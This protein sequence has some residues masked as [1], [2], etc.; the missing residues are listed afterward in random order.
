MTT[1]NARVQLAQRDAESLAVS[2]LKLREIRWAGDTKRIVGKLQDGTVAYEGGR[3]TRY[4]ERFTS[5]SAAITAIGSTSTELVCSAASL[6][7]GNTT[8]P[9]NVTLRI[10]KGGS[11]ALSGFTLAINGVFK[12]GPFQAFTGSGTV[13]FASYGSVKRALPEWWGAVADGST[14]CAS[15]INS[16]LSA[17]LTVK[18]VAGS[19]R[20]ASAVNLQ[21]GSVLCGDGR[22]RSKLLV[23]AGMTPNTALTMV[24][25]SNKNKWTVRDIGFDGNVANYPDEA[26][27]IP[28]AEPVV[29]PTLSFPSIT[30]I[31]AEIDT[32]TGAVDAG[33][34]INIERCH[35]ENITHHGVRFY[36]PA[37]TDAWKHIRVVHNSFYHGAYGG[38]NITVTGASSYNEWITV[39]DNHIQKNGP[40]KTLKPGFVGM[41]GSTD[42]IEIYKCRYVSV[43]NNIV[44]SPAGCGIRLEY[45]EYTTCIGNVVVNAGQEGITVY[46]SGV[47]VALLGN[48]IRKWGRLPQLQSLRRYPNAAS[49]NY[50]MPRET[51]KSGVVALPADPSTS[52]WWELNRYYLHGISP[53]TIP[54]YS[55]ANF[56]VDATPYAGDPTAVPPTGFDSANAQGLYPFR[57]FAGISV[58]QFT[59]KVFISGNI[60][61]GDTT[62]TGGL[63]NYASDYC[64][65][66]THNSNDPQTYNSPIIL[67]PNT[68]SGWIREAV[69]QPSFVD[70]I[71]RRGRIEG[72]RL[73]P[74]QYGYQNTSATNVGI[75][76]ELSPSLYE[77]I[78][79]SETIPSLL[80]GTGGWVQIDGATRPSLGTGAFGILIFCRFTSAL[81]SSTRYIFDMGLGGT[82]NTGCRVWVRNNEI[83][84]SMTDGVSNFQVRYQNISDWGVGDNKDLLLYVGRDADGTLRMIVNGDEM[85]AAGP[86]P[87][88]DMDTGRDV[89]INVDTNGVSVQ[90]IPMVLYKLVIWGQALT[91]DE[92]MQ[93]INEKRLIRF[94]DTVRF[95]MD[96]I[97]YGQYFVDKANFW[98]DR[99]AA[100]R[101]IYSSA[102]GV[103]ASHGRNEA[104]AADI[105][106]TNGSTWI[107]DGIDQ[108]ILPDDFYI[109]HAAISVAS[110]TP[111]VQA[112]STSGGSD[113]I[114]STPLAAGRYV[115]PINRMSETGKISVTS[116]STDS[117][118]WH[119]FG[120]RANGHTLG[121]PVIAGRTQGVKGASV[122]AANDMT[123]GGG[124][125]FSIT[126]GAAVIN[127]IATANWQAGSRVTLIF[128]ATPTVKNNTAASAG[129]ARIFLS[130]SADLAAA[131]NTVLV[132]EYDGTQ[133]QEVSRKIA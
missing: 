3:S 120:F 21:N 96:M 92:F 100:T 30:A 88:V 5:L 108:K 38:K 114:Q 101:V 50:Y 67:G 118:K 63:Y 61:E 126:A 111:T 82:V 42:G 109:T 14:D 73:F 4:L 20:I 74:G 36:D 9:V 104:F 48:V 32:S 19:Y 103:T 62:Q 16:A 39:E 95:D 33:A 76:K 102:S 89:G 44:D 8:I 29:N 65:S 60:I 23:A 75:P 7:T 69:Y 17:F 54:V 58:T 127:G 133:W 84:W 117:I 56:A 45:N 41:N 129:F 49:T 11:I 131:A 72:V 66:T 112:G 78:L 83:N 46:N 119:F 27:T 94:G 34:Y 79:H 121:T 80:F 98:A 1:Q 86:S 18:L 97:P 110:G 85:T 105:T 125:H 13:T 51:P 90:N 128:A 68:L 59:E 40:T 6:L 106:T 81:I 26:T 24:S 12:C 25:A 91:R 10:A 37:G 124:N 115:I 28:R 2:N 31:R 113:L 15:A 55:T 57:G 52:A 53:N 107:G 122:A 87:I 132:L 93:R 35:F 43:K 64:I 123:L 77:N 70:P 71:N 99:Y 116:T 130:G 47:Q 22:F